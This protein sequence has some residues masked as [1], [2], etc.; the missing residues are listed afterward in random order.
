VELL[1]K[2]KMLKV[3]AV[4]RF[5]FVAGLPGAGAD[6]L[7]T[8]L[9]QNPRF[10][11]RSDSDA[12]AVF[13]ELTTTLANPESAMSRLDEDC[14]TALLRGA[15]DA[16]YNARSL[17]AVVIDNNPGWIAQTAELARLMPLSRFIFIVRDPATSQSRDRSGGQIHDAMEHIEH[18]LGAE[19]S[20]RILLIERDRL[21][22][23]PV[24][25]LAVL[26]R[27]LREP[28]FEHDIR[29]LGPIPEGRTAT[30]PRSLR[31]IVSVPGLERRRSA[32]STAKPVPIW[33]R[34]P[35]TDA[36]LLLDRM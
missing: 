29:V 14:R 26:Y 3:M 17:D 34:A 11:A 25:V 28:N 36:T 1:N 9:A 27:F 6:L 16:V 5:H 20:E 31:R 15:F 12:F 19:Q 23:D 7:T 21:L 35:R 22:S 13:S 8:L 24:A 18:A 10:H 30:A 32:N 33:H 2:E 4:T